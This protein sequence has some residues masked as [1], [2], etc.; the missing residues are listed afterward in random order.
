MAHFRHLNLGGAVRAQ[1]EDATGRR[2][3]FYV[4]GTAQASLGRVSA[5]GN[6]ELGKDLANSTVFATNTF[7]TTLVGVSA[8]LTRQ[9]N[10]Q[11]EGFRTKLI[12]ALNPENMFVLQNQG[13][14]ISPILS[15]FNQWT[16]LFRLTRTLRWGGG[17]P[18]EGLDR[19]VAEHMPLTGAI[20]GFVYVLMAEG[21][22]PAPSVP[23]SLEDGKTVQ[24]DAKGGFRF[25][26]V[27]EG[28]HA[29]TIATDQLP[30]EY[31]PGPHPLVRVDIA[32]RRTAQAELDV[33]PLSALRGRVIARDG[34]TFDSL[35]GIL[36][37]VV[38]TG[39]Y[40]T[41]LRDGSFAFYNLPEGA[42]EL[43][44]GEDTLPPEAVLSTPARLPVVIRSN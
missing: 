19:F 12:A 39:Q 27:R 40:T 21:R 2:N 24:T 14:G 34:A 35:E 28:A 20:T 36:I 8:R 13:V 25:N 26:E 38:S 1:R 23:V 30:T 18:A 7:S 4:R 5:Y 43:T 17:L 42:Y 44:I 16:F 22:Q 11:A 10:F 29:V 41:T 3:S 9:W 6:L 31:N 33:Y 15:N 32:P 37:R